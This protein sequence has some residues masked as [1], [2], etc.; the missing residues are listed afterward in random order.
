MPPTLFF[1][2][3]S[4]QNGGSAEVKYEVQCRLHRPGW[5]KWDVEN[6]VSPRHALYFK[7]IRQQLNTHCCFPRGN[8]VASMGC[9]SRALC[10]GEQVKAAESFNC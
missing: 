6:S 8:I 1:D 4:E 3:P 5:L 2:T 10:I 9:T 7:P